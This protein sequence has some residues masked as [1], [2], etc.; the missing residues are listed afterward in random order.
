MEERQREGIQKGFKEVRTF[1]S[2]VEERE[3]IA[4]D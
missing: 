1:W 3:T 4:S 2:D